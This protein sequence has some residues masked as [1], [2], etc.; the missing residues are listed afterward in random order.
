MQT[1]QKVIAAVAVLLTGCNS[2]GPSI[3]ASRHI[4]GVLLADASD[5]FQVYLMDG[6]KEVAKA[7]AELEVI[8][9]DGKYDAGR[10]LQQAENLIS[11]Q[12]SVLVLMGC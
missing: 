2:S 7:D 12:V 11:Q 4:I 10:Q 8:Y 3:D 6:M 5:Q 1:I 9:M